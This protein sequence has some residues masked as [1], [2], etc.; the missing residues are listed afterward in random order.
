MTYRSQ[1][2]PADTGDNGEAPD[3]TG[4][5]TKDLTDALSWAP[6]EAGW[7]GYAHVTRLKPY[8]CTEV[9]CDHVRAE[10]TRRRQLLLDYYLAMLKHIP[11][12]RLLRMLAIARA[13]GGW[14]CY[15]PN[16]RDCAGCG[17][18]CEDIKTELATREHVPNK[19]EGQE[20]RRQTATRHSGPRSRR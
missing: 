3:L 16:P 7:E 14:Y 12:R 15:S 11:T 9:S 17:F 18:N 20:T 2:T 6:R 1:T 4:F 8:L 19:R 13:N 10:L 5:L